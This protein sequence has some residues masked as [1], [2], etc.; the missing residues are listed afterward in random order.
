MEDQMQNLAI[1]DDG[2]EF[3][4]IGGDPTVAD[5]K[6]CLV[7]MVLTDRRLNLVV[8][9]HR[10]AS[11]WRP[12]RG[13]KIIELEEGLILF[14]FY[15]IN[16]LR[17]VMDNEPWTFDN[18]LLLLHELKEGEI[19][20]TVS[21]HQVSIWV[22]FHGLPVE[23]F[24]ETVGAALGNFV[25]QFLSYDSKNRWSVGKPFMRVR[26]RLDVGKPLKKEKKIRKAGGDWFVCTFKFEKLPNFCFL[27]G[28]IGHIDRHCD[29]FFEKKPEELV[30]VWDASIR[31]P[32][33]RVALMGGERWL[34][35]DDENVAGDRGRAVDRPHNSSSNSRS[36]LNPSLPLLIKNFGATG[37]KAGGSELEAETG[38][39]VGDDRKRRRGE[40]ATKSA[41]TA[42]G[43]HIKPMDVD[44]GSEHTTKEDVPKN[45]YQA[46]PEVR[47]CP[48]S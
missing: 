19:P 43:V 29:I 45:V 28:L 15:H 47:V 30:R 8:F 13:M 48:S 44:K 40:D 23:F 18:N 9:K 2:F 7:G 3:K 31:A 34:R 35:E 14:R 25:G 46:D 17:W 36:Q 42:T 5:Y 24:T 16:D 39:Q 12:G 20:T 27:C 21:L 32:N 4:D 41:G 11:L 6:L 33:R 37:G 26:V 10:M 22:Q 38:L 1:I